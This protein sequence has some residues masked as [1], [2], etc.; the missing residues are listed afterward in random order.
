MH[1][2]TIAQ[3]LIVR[4]IN[5]NFIGVEIELIAPDIVEITDRKGEHMKLSININQ[6]ILDYDTRE[7]LST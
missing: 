3:Y 7:I 4:W 2:N 1:T 5:K 6:E